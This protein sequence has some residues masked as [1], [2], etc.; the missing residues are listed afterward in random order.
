MNNKV[1]IE[2]SWYQLLKNEF[3]KKYFSLLIEKV[4][5]AYEISSVFPPP[6][7]IFNA[8]KFTPVSQ[9]KVI[10]LGQDPYHK[11]GQAEGLSFSVPKNIKIPPSL[12]NIYKEIN[13]DLNIKIPNNGNLKRWANQGVCY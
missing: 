13:N 2:P 6:K 4:R 10:I 3:N 12:V 9:V 8:F 5:D 11:Q 1:I 7:L